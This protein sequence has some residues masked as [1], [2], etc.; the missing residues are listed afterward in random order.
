MPL[1]PTTQIPPGYPQT[2][3]QGSFS[4]RFPTPEHYLK[5]FGQHQIHQRKPQVHYVAEANNP[6]SDQFQELHGKG[7]GRGGAK[8]KAGPKKPGKPRGKKAVVSAALADLAAS[9]VE[10]LTQQH[11]TKPALLEQSPQWLASTPS[12]LAQTIKQEKPDSDGVVL[13][14][15]E[16][17]MSAGNSDPRDAVPNDSLEGSKENEGALSQ[18]IKATKGAPPEQYTEAKSENSSC[19]ASSTV[20]A[21]KDTSL[22]D[23][24]ITT[25]ESDSPAPAEQDANESVDKSKRPCNGTGLEALQKLESMVADMAN[26]EEACKELEK[27]S[28]LERLLEDEEYDP[29]M[30]K[31]YDRDF[32]EE[33][34]YE[35][36]LLSPAKAVG[37]GSQANSVASLEC[38]EESLISPLLEETERRRERQKFF[39]ESSSNDTVSVDKKAEDVTGN[40]SESKQQGKGEMPLSPSD[41]SD[42]TPCNVTNP[43]GDEKIDQIVSSADPVADQTKCVEESARDMSTDCVVE[44]G[45]EIQ[46]KRTDDNQATQEEACAQ[47][48]PHE[49]DQCHDSFASQMLETAAS[50][51]ILPKCEPMESPISPDAVNKVVYTGNGDIPL[52]PEAEQRLEGEHFQSHAPRDICDTFPQHNAANV[53]SSIAPEAVHETVNQIPKPLDHIQSS[54]LQE[55][56]PANPVRPPQREKPSKTTK[57]P[58]RPKNQHT[59][60][61]GSVK[62]K[63]S[64]KEEDPMK[65]QLQELRRQEYERKKREYEEQQKKKRELQKELRIQKQMIREQRKRQRIYMNSNNRSKQKAEVESGATASM[66]LSTPNNTHRDLKPASPLSLCE[67]KLLLTHALTH[68]YGSRPFNGQCL[69]KGNFGSAKVDGEVDYYSQFPTPDMDIVVGHPPTPPSSLPPSPGVHQHRNDSTGKPLVNGDVSPEQRERAELL[70]MRKP[71]ARSQDS[72][73]PAKRARYTGALESSRGGVSVPPSMPTPPLSDSAATVNDRLVEVISSG[74]PLSSAHAEANGKESNSSSSSTSP[75]T[76][77]YIASSSPESDALNRVQTP[78]FSALLHRECTDSPTF[79][80]VTIKCEQVEHFLENGAPRSC[81]QSCSNVSD[82]NCVQT[83][84]KLEAGQ[85]SR[86]END[87]DDLDN[88]HVTLTLSPTSEQRVTDT[89]ASVADLIGCSPPRRSDIVIEPAGKGLATKGYMTPHSLTSPAGDS[90]MAPRPHTSLD[91]YQKNPFPCSI[92]PSEEKS[93]RK[94]LEGPYCR[95][96]DVLIIGI[97]VKRKPEEE[98]TVT[99]VESNQTES[100]AAAD[101]KIY[102]VNV[103][104]GDCTGDI[105]CSEA[106]LKQYFAHFG[107]E[108]SSPTQECKSELKASQPCVEAT[109]TSVGQTSV[110]A[111]NVT[112][113]SAVDTHRGGV[114]AD[115]LSP[116]SLRKIRSPSWK[117]EDE[118]DE[119]VSVL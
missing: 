2:T 21:K 115:G 79:P 9:Q 106:C 93:S 86:L 66:K 87:S 16:V 102:G 80:A 38:H 34:Q 5:Q 33:T 88:I 58:S 36:N 94:K 107:S 101:Y 29:E 57:Q 109:V 75:E 71:R 15:S 95:H 61:E 74:K 39:A 85:A 69:L 3:E 22:P 96:C 17:Q 65:K 11:Q 35:Q 78:K 31:M 70:A 8:K 110:G 12:Q 116:T 63:P 14:T 82:K 27:Q 119:E 45:Q 46:P 4:Q 10:N 40:E 118:E 60:T 97:G 24:E 111:G 7:R 32:M 43:H 49:Q 62:K 99:T 81:S 117:E 59:S 6:F 56:I 112:A 100:D 44:A 1:Q 18:E 55:P 48:V 19:N 68:P 37:N 25:T 92:S 76:V 67:P 42:S 26:E 64:P 84:C 30:D 13:E 89:V 52:S 50:G 108:C 90:S 73:H 91:I 20:D 54:L 83:M 72:E 104:A 51:L 47:N 113:V 114:V 53:A 105:F 103:E 77:Q 41:A 28:E 23:Q 98:E